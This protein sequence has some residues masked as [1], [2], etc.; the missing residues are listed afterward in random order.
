VVPSPATWESTTGEAQSPVRP[1]SLDLLGSLTS[2]LPI[3]MADYHR[4]HRREPP[5]RRLNRHGYPGAT[6]V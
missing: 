1:R 5:A 4:L 2:G 6:C 3:A